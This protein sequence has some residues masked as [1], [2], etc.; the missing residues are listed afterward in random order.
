MKTVFT[1]ACGEGNPDGTPARHLID[2]VADRERLREA[3]LV[4]RH[5]GE[6]HLLTTA[7]ALSGEALPEQ[8]RH[9]IGPSDPGV[10]RD[11][12]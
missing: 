10:P 7:L 11:R 2:T 4:C 1:P 8:P 9:K 12:R 5:C 6:A 3:V